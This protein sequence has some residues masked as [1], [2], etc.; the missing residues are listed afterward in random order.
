[1][2]KRL[3]EMLLHDNIITKQQLKKALDYHKEK[4]CYIGDALLDLGS[5]TQEILTKYLDM[6]RQLIEREEKIK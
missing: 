6:Q 4:S 1:M 3:G 5:I 2:R